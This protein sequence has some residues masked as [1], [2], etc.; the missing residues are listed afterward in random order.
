M[1]PACF[2]AANFGGPDC[3]GA[4]KASATTSGGLCSECAGHLI[5]RAEAAEARIAQLNT[6]IDAMHEAAVAA[7]QGRA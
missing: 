3:I 7:R 4:R 2:F 6:R 1:N 5:A